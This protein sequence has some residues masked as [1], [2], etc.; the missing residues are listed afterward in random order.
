MTAKCHGVYMAEVFIVVIGMGGGE[1]FLKCCQCAKGGGI[2]NCLQKLD[3]MNV[4]FD[5]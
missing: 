1:G 2:V 4:R 3:G 5:D